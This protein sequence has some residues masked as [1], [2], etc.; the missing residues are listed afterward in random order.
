M[1]MK[2]RESRFVIG[3]N[4]VPHCVDFWGVV[5]PNVGTVLIPQDDDLFLRCFADLVGVELASLE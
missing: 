2:C 3:T 4:D 5:I 1:S